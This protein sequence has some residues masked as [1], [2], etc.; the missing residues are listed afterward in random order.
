VAYCDDSIKVTKVS[1][2][3][4]AISAWLPVLL[5]MDWWIRKRRQ[6][7]ASLRFSHQQA[8]QSEKHEARLAAH[9]VPQ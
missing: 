5:V 3:A 6:E 8:T 2:K 1:V 7:L 4:V 9:H